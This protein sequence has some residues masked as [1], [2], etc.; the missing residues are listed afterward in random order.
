MWGGVIWDSWKVSGECLVG[1]V[2]VNRLNAFFLWDE[3]RVQFARRRR[4]A[5]TVPCPD[6]ETGARDSFANLWQK[7]GTRAN[8]AMRCIE[9]PESRAAVAFLAQM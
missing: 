1:M 8:G 2:A 5:T 4:G 9:S 7:T 3:V 6:Y